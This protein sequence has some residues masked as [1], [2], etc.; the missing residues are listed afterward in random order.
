MK[1]K[2]YSPLLFLRVILV[3]A[4][5]VIMVRTQ[6]AEKN[7]SV[8]VETMEAKIMA[9]VDAGNMMEKSTNRMFK[10]FYGLNAG[11]YDGVVFYKPVSGMNAEEMVIIRLADNSQAEAA[12][13]AIE[14]RLASQK[15]SLE[16]YGV[17]QTAL[18]N[19][20]VLQSHGNYVFY[21]VHEKAADAG[22]A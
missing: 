18:L 3:I 19:Q 21:I 22:N 14:Q 5:L 1:I 16:G 17:E 10:K 8:S 7:S 11:D 12:V 6:F 13:Q 2:G 9:V 20:P 4:L 15:N